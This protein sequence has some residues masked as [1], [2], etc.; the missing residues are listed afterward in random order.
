MFRE[1]ATRKIDGSAGDNTAELKRAGKFL[2]A[3][4]IGICDFDE[5]WVYTHNY[6]RQKLTDKPMDL[7]EDLTSVVVIVNEMHHQTIQT[8]PSALSGAATGQGYSRDIIAV[9]SIT[10]YIRNLRLPSHCQPQRYRTV[11]PT[12][13]SSRALDNTAGMVC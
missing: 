12:G 13:D 10:Q 9:L 2:G 4:A 5:R 7:P 1:G 6:S 3:D 8:V 11:N